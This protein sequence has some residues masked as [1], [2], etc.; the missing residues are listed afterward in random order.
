[1]GRMGAINK[2]QVL[3]TFD[4]TSGS[5]FSK[6]WG[7]VGKPLS[8]DVFKNKVDAEVKWYT[9]PFNK[10]NNWFYFD[11][12]FVLNNT[13]EYAQTFVNSPVDQ[14]VYMRTGTSG[15]LKIWVND[16]LTTSVSGRKKLR[17]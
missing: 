10:F 9:P 14:T 11:F 7:V 17:S 6:D 13:I 8:S 4:N 3:G 1:M 16:A 5:G 12:Y 2:W 15:S